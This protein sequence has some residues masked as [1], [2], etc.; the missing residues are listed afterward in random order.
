MKFTRL[1]FVYSTAK[2]S[3][4]PCEAENTEKMEKS[5]LVGVAVF[6]GTVCTVSTDTDEASNTPTVAQWGSL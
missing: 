2:V 1:P 5:P 6:V 3:V 4:M